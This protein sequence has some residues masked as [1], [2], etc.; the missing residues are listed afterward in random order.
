MNLKLLVP[1]LRQSC[2]VALAHHDVG[3]VSTRAAL[4]IAFDQNHRPQVLFF[5]DTEGAKSPAHIAY[6]AVFLT[7]CLPSIVDTIAG[8]G[9]P[10][11][12]AV[13]RMVNHLLPNLA[14]L[15]YGTKFTDARLLMLAD[16]L[17]KY[18]VAGITAGIANSPPPP[19]KKLG[20]AACEH[21]ERN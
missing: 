19:S 8:L 3:I 21:P 17:D 6:A 13:E 20:L 12:Q 5:A 14:K 9:L 16:M 11:E 2:S 7:D 18:A 1:T 4:V 15:I 10:H